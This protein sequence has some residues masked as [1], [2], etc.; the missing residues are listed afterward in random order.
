MR[1]R[2]AGWFAWDVPVAEIA[3]LLRVSTNAVY[4]WRRR[5]RA[6]GPGAL[7]SKGVGG[8]GLPAG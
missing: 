2:A 1:L 6:G 7:A 5:W 8:A 3:G 4:V